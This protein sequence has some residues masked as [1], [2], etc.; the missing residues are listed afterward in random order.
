[1]EGLTATVIYCVRA[2]GLFLCAGTAA[3]FG[4][5]LPFTDA[6]YVVLGEAGAVLVIAACW[7]S[8]PRI[9]GSWRSDPPSDKQLE[10]ADSLGIRIPRNVTKGRLSDMIEAAKQASG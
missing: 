8:W 7:L 5:M 10:Y 6:S 4:I 3:V 2:V 9:P 1:M